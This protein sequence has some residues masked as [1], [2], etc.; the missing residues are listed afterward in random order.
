MRHPFLRCAAAVLCAS[1][2]VLAG[3][4][5]DDTAT[6]TETTTT[7]T[8]APPGDDEPATPEEPA[9]NPV[10]EPET[11]G[12]TIEVQIRDGAVEGGG[13]TAVALGDTVTIR[14]TSDVADH[15]HVHGYDVL[16]IS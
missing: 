5:D 14:V 3:C 1:A 7:T 4:G 6:D 16:E 15:V 13:R 8:T 2:L 12:T 11:D 10:D 9:D